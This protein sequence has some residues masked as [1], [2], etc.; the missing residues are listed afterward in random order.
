MKKLILLI[1][2]LSIVSGLLAQA[3]V[4]KTDTEFPKEWELQFKLTNGLVT[5]FHSTA[6]DM[7]TGGLGLSAQY[8]VVPHKLRLGATAMAVYN[9]KKLGGLFGPSVALKLK[10]LDTKLFGIGNIHLLAEH[11]WGTD[12][13]RLLGGG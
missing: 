1:S 5:N 2:F 3:P 4:V 9:N 11:L 10:S 8:G 6:P 7:Y 13:Q 12:K